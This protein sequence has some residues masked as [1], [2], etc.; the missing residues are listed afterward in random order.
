[1]GKLENEMMNTTLFLTTTTTVDQIVVEGDAKS[2]MIAAL[3][4]SLTASTYETDKKN[5]W[6]ANSYIDSLSDTELYEMEQLLQ[7]KEE[8]WVTHSEHIDESQKPKRCL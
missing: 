8:E 4:S 2:L 1:M 7:E 6:M 5:V 3:A